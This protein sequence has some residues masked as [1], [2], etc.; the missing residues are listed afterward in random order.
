MKAINK[1]IP[2]GIDFLMQ[3]GIAFAMYSRAPVIERI[4]KIIPEIRMITRPA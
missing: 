4:K 1:P 2:A 3:S